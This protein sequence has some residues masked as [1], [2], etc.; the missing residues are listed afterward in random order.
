MRS[1]GSISTYH[2]PSHRAPYTTVP[3]PQHSWKLEHFRAVQKNFNGSGI[4]PAPRLTCTDNHLDFRSLNYWG[5]FW[6]HR[7]DPMHEYGDRER[8]SK[9][10]KGRNVKTVVQWWNTKRSHDTDGWVLITYG[11]T[12]A[13]KYGGTRGTYNRDTRTSDQWLNPCEHSHGLSNCP[14]FAHCLDEAQ[15]CNDSKRPAGSVDCRGFNGVL[16]NMVFL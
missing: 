11:R 5:V 15:Q 2:I 7:Q 9:Q 13:C 3:N 6:T 14:L 4:G 10:D 1:A 8:V 12:S 16:M